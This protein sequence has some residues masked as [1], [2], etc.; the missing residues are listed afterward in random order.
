MKIIGERI[1]ILKKE[2]VL[3]IVILPVKNKTKL[4]LMFAWLL[5]WS[6]C[7]VIVFAN[8]FQ[9]SSRDAK[10]FV[11]VYLSFWAYFEVN[12]I[13]AFMWKKS[14]KE[15]IWIQDGILHYQKEVN[16]KGKVKEYNLSLMSKLDLVELK[17]TNFLDTVTQ[18]FWYKGGERLEFRSQAA[19]V[20]LGMQ[21]SD[22]EARG[23]MREINP[24]IN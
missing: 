9:L 19:V 10:L 1:S 21:L 2:D 24:Y 18:S 5:A 3:S 17:A 23:I 13:R 11:I 4:W 12:I 16:K 22:D 6:V 15:K 14:G 8:Y 20:R 7:G